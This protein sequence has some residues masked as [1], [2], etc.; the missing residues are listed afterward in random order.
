MLTIIVDYVV[1][2]LIFQVTFYTIEIAMGFN[3]LMYLI[4]TNVC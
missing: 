1:I 2:K 3:G 4:A